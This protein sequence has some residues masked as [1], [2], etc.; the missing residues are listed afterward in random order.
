MRNRLLQAAMTLALVATAF[1]AVPGLA[2]EPE[3][4]SPRAQQVHVVFIPRRRC[5]LSTKVA[6]TVTR[7]HKEIG[8]AFKAGELLVSLDDTIYSANLDKAEAKLKSAKAELASLDKT[9]Y[10]ANL[11]KAKAKL[12]SA[13]ISATTKNSLFKDNAISLSEVAA[14][15]AAAKMARADVVIARVRL[16]LCQA[17]AEKAKAAVAMARADVVMAQAQ[18]AA[19]G[20]KAPYAGRVVKILAQEHENVQSGYKLIEILDDNTLLAKFFAPSI[21]AN[22]IRVGTEITISVRETG[23]DVAG[24]ISHIMPELNTTS[25]TLTVFAEVQN[26]TGND[27]GKG[28]LCGGMRGLLDLSFL[29]KK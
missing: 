17:E 26:S 2:A 16:T 15:R 7:T 27:R 20:V 28:R 18:V 14:A 1:P 11:D 25:S 5:V 22:K 13:E 29:E 3:G 10:A 9:I 8:Q 21:Y 19:C 24:K 4:A 23:A 6:S 12:E